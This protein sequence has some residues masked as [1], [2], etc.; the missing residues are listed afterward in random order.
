MM[1][2]SSLIITRILDVLF[3]LYCWCGIGRSN[4]YCS[5][6]SSKGLILFARGHGG[7]SSSSSNN[8]SSSS[9]NIRR[10]R[11]RFQSILRTIPIPVFEEYTATTAAMLRNYRGGGN[12]INT[13]DASSS[14]SSSSITMKYKYDEHSAWILRQQQEQQQ[15]HQG[16]YTS[17]L[18]SNRYQSTGS[19]NTS[20]TAS[21]TKKK[22]RS[23]PSSYV[24]M[25]YLMEISENYCAAVRTYCNNLH[26]TSTISYWILIGTIAVY[27]SWQVLPGYTRP[28]L[29]SYFLASRP[30]AI[31]T[32][33][34][35]LFLSTISHTSFLHVLVN[36]YVFLNLVP[37]VASSLESSRSSSSKT[38]RNVVFLSALS[39]S[40]SLL[41][42]VIGGG[43]CGNLL[44]LCFRPGGSCLG[45]SG[46]N[47]SMLSVYA[48]AHPDQTIRMLLLG[49]IPV[50]L[51]AATLV[52]LL[53][54]VSLS[55]SLF[56]PTDSIAHL[57]HL[58]GLI[59]GGLYYHY[60]IQ[61]K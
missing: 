17:M 47:M 52:Q 36:V 46:V 55:G 20:S 54:V 41:P 61:T 57:A 33:G 6:S 37:V 13:E 5:S 21:S 29:L 35:S 40:S 14:P 49:I 60:I 16:H 3:V 10:R 31:R 44:F 59:F 22:T 1:I 11:Q 28:V 42:I 43:L 27:L 25:K 2:R 48:G 50:S 12:Y 15:Q 38:R 30:T 4:N 26:R 56:R 24:S 53:C 23:L 9:S 34:A 18:S 7:S 58:G 32:Y 39:P 8:N 45:L 19:I 51:K